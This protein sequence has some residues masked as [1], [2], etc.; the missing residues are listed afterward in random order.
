M[1]EIQKTVKHKWSKQQENSKFRASRAHCWLTLQQQSPALQSWNSGA[2]LSP[3]QKEPTGSK[4]LSSSSI[5]T[6]K[7]LSLLLFF[8]FLE[9]FYF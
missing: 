9:S 1:R 8:L 6:A 4:S 5:P 7:R 3:G 2:L